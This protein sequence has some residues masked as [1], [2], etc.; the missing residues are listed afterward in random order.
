[1]AGLYIRA[2]Q[3]VFRVGVGELVGG[4]DRLTQVTSSQR[5][6][7]SEPASTSREAYAAQIFGV[8]GRNG[9][10]GPGE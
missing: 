5:L 6:V 8:V 4:A 3:P 7:H 10:V 9:K 1:M 2:R